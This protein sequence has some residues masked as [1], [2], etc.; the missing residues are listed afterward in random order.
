MSLIQNELQQH[1]TFLVT[2]QRCPFCIKAKELLEKKGK[3]YHE[4]DAEKNRDL[5]D[6][7][8]NAQAHMTFPMIYLDGKFV[9][10]Y[11]Q[12][13]KFYNELENKANK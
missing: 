6:E 9:G 4:I 7:I 13:A 3:K 10:G 5:V 8:K 1:S 2:K 11:D 12:L